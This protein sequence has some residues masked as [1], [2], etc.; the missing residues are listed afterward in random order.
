[1]M[2]KSFYVFALLSLFFIVNMMSMNPH[3]CAAEATK[4]NP[5]YLKIGKFFVLYTQPASPFVD[6]KQRIL[7][8]LRSIQDLMGGTVDYDQQDKKAT[9]KWVNHTFELTIGSSEAMVDQSLVKMD[10]TPVLKDGAM[11]LPMRLFLDHAD[12]AYTWN[13]KK[14]YLHLTDER[15]AKGKAF[16]QFAGND[17]SDVKKDDAFD[18]LSY[19]LIPQ[20]NGSTALIIKAQNV[21]GDKIA[22]G[23]GDIHPL[24]SYANNNGFST[25][26]YS[27]PNNP[28]LQAVEKDASIT[29]KQKFENVKNAAYIISVGRELN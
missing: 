23:K 13:P 1:M 3:V 5:I 20:K 9:V 25:D 19:Q 2:K 4:E 26:S 24:V 16:E 7:V 15:V 6:A 12:V 21:S 22:K 28:P 17:F 27:R 14:H 11:F 8:P 18:L 10:T 29:M